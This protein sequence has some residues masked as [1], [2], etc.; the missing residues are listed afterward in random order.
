MLIY[1]AMV[2]VAL[3]SMSPSR[4][5][6]HVEAYCARLVVEGCDVPMQNHSGGQQSN[7]VLH[8]EDGRSFPTQLTRDLVERREVPRAPM[9]ILLLKSWGEYYG[10]FSNLKAFGARRWNFS[11]K[12]PMALYATRVGGRSDRGR[13]RLLYTYES[14][15]LVPSSSCIDPLFDL[16]I[17]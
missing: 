11:F 12:T 8:E 13:C 16:L 2:V 1:A 15:K 17:P 7:R 14:L 9:L 5:G 10:F 3:Q 6:I 4:Q